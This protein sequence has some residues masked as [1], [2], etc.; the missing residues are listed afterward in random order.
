VLLLASGWSLCGQED[1]VSGCPES[2]VTPPAGSLLETDSV[3]LIRSGCEGACPEYSVRIFR[4]G[5]VSWRGR[6]FVAH[7]GRR[8]ASISRESALAVLMRFRETDVWNLCGSYDAMI[9][10]VPGFTVVVRIGEQTKTIRNRAQGAPDWYSEL[11]GELDLAA[12]TQ[13]WL[14]PGG[15]LSP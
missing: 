7:R 11:V 8:Q 9:S 3:E 2:D 10:D 5:D 14:C 13:R 6:S 12:G 4:N 1:S 15:C